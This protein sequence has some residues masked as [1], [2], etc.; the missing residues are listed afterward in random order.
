MLSRHT[1]ATQ[2]NEVR[3]V[4]IVQ[5]TLINIE[6]FQRFYTTKEEWIFQRDQLITFPLSRRVEL[7]INLSHVNYIRRSSETLTRFG[8]I[9]V[10]LNIVT[11]WFSDYATLNYYLEFNTGSGGDYTNLN[12]HPLEAYGHEE[13]RTGLILFKNLPNAFISIHGNLFYVF[14]SEGE[15]TFFGAFLNEGIFNIFA[16]EAYNQALG[17]NPVHEKTFF[18]YKNF[19]NDNFEINFAINTAVWYPF[20]PFIEIT[21][22][23]TFSRNFQRKAIGS[24]IMRNQLSVGSK[25]FLKDDHFSF[26]SSLLIPIPNL[27]QLYDI[28]WGFGFQLNF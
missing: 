16:E 22:S 3:T 10:F 25:F 24:G 4:T 5:D 19:V 6:I 7:G 21:T 8:D 15:P 20:V 28:A 9:H 13:W 17:F 12:N 26:K 14:R 18:Y 27:N 1:F 23:F 11:D 2:L